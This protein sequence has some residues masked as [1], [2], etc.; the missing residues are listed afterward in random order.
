LEL[1]LGGLE[2]PQ[3]EWTDK[4]EVYL[5]ERFRGEK[6]YPFQVFGAGSRPVGVGVG[7]G[8]GSRVASEVIRRRV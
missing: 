7:S 8:E 3:K 5:A 1:W 4:I 2:P 6:V